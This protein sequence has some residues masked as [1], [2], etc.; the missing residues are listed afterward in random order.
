MKNR[1]AFEEWLRHPEV[2][3]GE[4]EFAGA[5]TDIRLKQAGLGFFAGRQSLLPVIE[6]VI[7]KIGEVAGHI[8]AKSNRYNDPKLEDCFITLNQ[9]ATQL[10]STLA[11]IEGE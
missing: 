8:G 11:E 1:E 2:T 3:K 6:E 5:L 10:Q 9:V 7:E 4:R